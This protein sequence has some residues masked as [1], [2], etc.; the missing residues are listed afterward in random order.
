[1]STGRPKIRSGA[2][3]WIAGPVQYLIAQLVAQAAWR[4]PY[5]W[6][7]NPLSDLGAVHCQRTG[8]GYPLPRYVCSPLHGIVNASVIALGVLLAG[9]VLLTAPCWGRG[10][11]SRGAR[12]LLIAAAAGSVLVGLVPEDV[13]PGLHLLGAFAG[14]VVGNCGFVLAGLVRRGSPLGKLWPVTLPLSILAMTAAVLLFTGAIP[15]GDFGGVERLAVFPL[16]CWMVIAGIFLLHRTG[17]G[18]GAGPASRGDP[19][20]R[21]PV[22]AADQPA[23]PQV[24]TGVPLS[25]S[26]REYPA[27][28]GRSGTQRARGGH[29]HGSGVRRRPSSGR[30]HQPP[31]TV[32]SAA[33]RTGQVFSGTTELE[34]SGW[35]VRQR[36]HLSVGLLPDQ[37]LVAP[38]IG[39]TLEASHLLETQGLDHTLGPLVEGGNGHPERGRGEPV[40]AEVQPSLDR[41]PPQPD[42]GK[43]GAQ[44]TPGVERGLVVVPARHLAVLPERAETNELVPIEQRKEAA[45]RMGQEVWVSA[46]HVIAVIRRRVTPRGDGSGVLRVHGNDPH[47]ASEW[48]PSPTRSCCPDSARARSFPRSCE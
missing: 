1:M 8:S 31:G 35:R 16:R 9:G 47:A 36:S 28:T 17:Q 10:V 27:L 20:L 30:S 19:L 39:G 29:A 4:T 44:A 48:T 14:I 2:V 12:I 46:C 43:F 5:S 45:G 32:R 41:L 15:A 22:C 13:N 7:I 11:A 6:L 21:R 37:D 23:H 42:P 25:I 34:M 3:M 40:A 24:S 26:D 33:V 18:T 38:A